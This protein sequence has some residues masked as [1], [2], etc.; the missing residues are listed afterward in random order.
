[1][2]EFIFQVYCKSYISNI[3]N[4]SSKVPECTQL[5]SRSLLAI[6]TAEQ[7]E[8]GAG[9]IATELDAGLLPDAQQINNDIKDLSLDIDTFKASL[10]DIL[11]DLTKYT[12]GTSAD[13][14][15]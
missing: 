8:K 11:T 14:L 10:Q 2:T 15:E 4:C 9:I 12:A 3:R 6:A 1:M 7:L 13:I 5:K